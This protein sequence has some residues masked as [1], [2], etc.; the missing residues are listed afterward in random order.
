ME[1]KMTDLRGY[2]IEAE[3]G[4][5]GKVHDL[6]FDDTIWIVRY[7]VV[8]TGGWIH[9]NR[10]LLS[11]L[12]FRTPDRDAGTLPVQCTRE[13]VR[14]SPEVDTDKPV[15]RQM[16]IDLHK[17]FGWPFYWGNG[18]GVAVS[19]VIQEHEERIEK[20]NPDPHLRSAREV[21]GYTVHGKDDKIGGVGDFIV[22][23]G[24]WIVRQLVIDTGG[25]FHRNEVRLP[26]EFLQ[27][28]DWGTR[29]IRINL[30][31]KEIEKGEPFVPS[32]PPPRSIREDEDRR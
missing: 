29:T 20:E 6:Y 8:D 23:D 13:Q 21:I 30:G 32:A 10:V 19:Q 27:S 9:C 3:D 15:S 1:W 17:Y 14:N 12:A 2:D 18:M 31:S 16:E 24:T 4:K 22:D 5:I 25:L 26:I 11:P 28:V 7:L